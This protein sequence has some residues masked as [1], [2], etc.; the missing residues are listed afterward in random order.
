MDNATNIA[1]SVILVLPLREYTPPSLSSTIH[2]GHERE[3]TID[4][5]PELKN[6]S[7]PGAVDKEELQQP[8]LICTLGYTSQFMNGGETTRKKKLSK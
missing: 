7:C 5:N 2:Q 6:Y 8:L 3:D 1:Y 4:D